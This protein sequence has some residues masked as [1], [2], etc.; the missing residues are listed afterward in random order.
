MRRT[1]NP[2]TL[3]SILAY[4]AITFSTAVLIAGSGSV[5]AA[6]VAK[7]P[8][9]DPAGADAMLQQIDALKPPEVDQSKKSDDAYRQQYVAQMRKVMEEKADLQGKFAA[10]Y[11]DNPKA[12]K[13]RQDRWMTLA[14]LGQTDKVAEEANDLLKQPGH[15]NDPDAL[16]MLAQLAVMKNRANPAAAQDAIDRFLQA[17][18]KDDRGARLLYMSVR[19]KTDDEHG[20]EVAKRIVADYP[21]S[22]VAKQIQ[23]QLRRTEAIGKPFDLNFTEAVSGK[24]ISMSDLKGKVVVVDFWATW[25]G[26]CVGEMP[27]MK[28]LYADYKPKGVEFIGVSLDQP[29][30]DGGLKELKEFVAKEG[31]SWPQYYQGNGWESEFSKSWGV[32]SIP[33]VFVVDADGNLANTEARG[34][35]EEL[36]PELLKKRD[37][38]KVSDASR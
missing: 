10:A 22:D 17:A 24:P 5:R 20:K 30:K 16:Y 18:P 28:K 23:G 13:M 29:E 4:M 26:P 6:D 2:T 11:P 35:L 25:C 1:A 8:A 34:K 19:G 38:G 14:Q 31:I 37:A 21:N 12:G 33:C 7:P 15:A 3:R 9:A 32:N 36:I 27:T